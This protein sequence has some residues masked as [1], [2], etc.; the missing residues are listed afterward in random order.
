MK[1]KLRDKLKRCLDLHGVPLEVCGFKG[2]TTPNEATAWVYCEVMQL[3]RKT[4]YAYIYFHV[5][6][7]L[8]GY[9]LKHS[10]GVAI[11]RRSIRRWTMWLPGYM[12]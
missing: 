3:N 6:E 8:D 1:D 7:F 2:Y 12:Y 9:S 11:M 5:S 4:S 10:N